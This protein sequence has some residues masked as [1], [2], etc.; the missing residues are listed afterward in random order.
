MIAHPDVSRRRPRW[1]LWIA[2]AVAGAGSIALLGGVVHGGRS[3][4]SSSFSTAGDGLGAYAQLVGDEGH[5]VSRL[6]NHFQA[7]TTAPGGVL[8]VADPSGM[9]TDEENAIGRFVRGGGRLVAAGTGV[10]ALLRQLLGHGAPVWSATG[11]TVATAVGDSPEVAGVGRIAAAGTGSWLTVGRTQPVLEGDG[12]V[13]AVVTDLGAG[14]VVALADASVLQNRLL[15]QD[16]N[17][18]FGLRALGPGGVAVVFDE[19]DHGYGNGL[20]A[21]PERWRLALVV[22]TLAAVLWLVGAA[23]RLG[24]PEDGDDQMDPPRVRHIEALGAALERTGAGRP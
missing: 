14:R 9:S 10:Q 24:P 3:P 15:G 2:V 19:A 8:I 11:T 16:D 17:A 22:A 1:L 18:A 21:L 7:I 6:R 5:R 23:R 20:A 4:T 12:A 13:M